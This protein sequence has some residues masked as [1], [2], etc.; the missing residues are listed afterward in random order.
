MKVIK[1]NIK[2]LLEVAEENKYSMEMINSLK[3][4]IK[5]INHW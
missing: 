5:F 1:E 3:R 2:I 4:L